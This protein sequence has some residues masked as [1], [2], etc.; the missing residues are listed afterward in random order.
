MGNLRQEH[1]EAVNNLRNY[2]PGAGRTV[3]DLLF[4]GS[5]T[6]VKELSNIDYDSNSTLSVA[7]QQGL[8]DTINGGKFTHEI[9]SEMST[10]L[11]NS[12]V[13]TQ[14]R[15]SR[16]I[17]LTIPEV[18]FTD[19]YDTVVSNVLLNET[20]KYEVPSNEN[21]LP[22]NK[23][24][25]PID[26]ILPTGIDGAKDV[27]SIKTPSKS[28]TP[29]VAY[30]ILSNNVGLNV[31][32]TAPVSIACNLMTQIA[33]S[34]C[35]PYLNVKIF[36]GDD[37]DSTNIVAGET[38]GFNLIHFLRGPT[39]EEDLGSASPMILTLNNGNKV[40]TPSGMELFTSP[41]T[42]I[43][44]P[45]DLG[46]FLTG[47]RP[48][49]R[50]RPLMTI[51]SFSVQVVSAGAGL[52]NNKTAS[53]ELTLHD[54]GRLA[55]IKQLV[56][57]G[58]YSK[59]QIEVEYGWS[60]IPGSTNADGL[61]SVN[62]I[63]D[64]LVRFMNSIRVKEKYQVTT[65]GYK[66]EEGGQISISLGL[67][68]TGAADAVLL[69]II[70][71][72]GTPAAKVVKEAI[73][74]INQIFLKNQK[75]KDI[76]GDTVA[77]AVSTADY[78]L[79][80]D[81][82]KTQ[83][84]LDAVS[85]AS[86]N[87]NGSLKESASAVAASLRNLFGQDENSVIQAYK[88]SMKDSITKKLQVLKSENAHAVFPSSADP[89]RPV[90]AYVQ[91]KT[92][93]AYS[94]GWINLGSIVIGLVAAPLAASKKFDEIQVIFGRFNDRANFM[95]SLSVASFP[96]S[97][98]DFKTQID[99]LIEENTN[100]TPQQLMQMIADKFV[101]SPSDYAYGFRSG[102]VPKDDGSLEFSAKTGQSAQDA[103]CQNAGIKD[104]V[105]RQ[106]RLKMYIE[107]VPHV[108]KPGVSILRI[109]VIDETCSAFST[110]HDVLWAARESDSFLI[111]KVSVNSQHPNFN[112]S[113]HP[114]EITP[115]FVSK[116][117]ESILSDLEKSGVVSPIAKVTS[118]A[119]PSPPPTGEQLPSATKSVSDVPEPTNLFTTQDV[120][121]MRDYF[122]RTLPTITYGA[123]NGMINSISAGVTADPA[124]ATIAI[125]NQDQNN[126]ETS[127]AE[128]RTG[129]VPLQA[130]IADVSIEML[131]NPMLGFAQEFFIDLGTNTTMDSIYV[132]T[133]IDHKIEPGN[134]TTSLKLVAKNGYGLYQSRQRMVTKLADTLD[135]INGNS[136]GPKPSTGSGR[137]S[138]TS[139]SSYSSDVSSLSFYEAFLRCKPEKVMAQEKSNG[140]AFVLISYENSQGYVP[141]YKV[142]AWIRN[143]KVLGLGPFREQRLDSDPA[144]PAVPQ[145]VF[146]IWLKDASAP[147]LSP[148]LNLGQ[149]KSGDYIVL[150]DDTWFTN[151][152]KDRTCPAYRVEKIPGNNNYN[153][154][155][156]LIDAT[157]KIKASFFKS[158]SEPYLTYLSQER[159][160]FAA[161]KGD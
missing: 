86:A 32:D 42:L 106:P 1:D 8:L 63:D 71:D 45:D 62:K 37:N 160:R 85:K 113:N 59:V 124:I 121:K 96:I 27:A 29:I 130:F 158:I 111:E 154:N 72:T 127:Q 19:Y 66:F 26:A 128:G 105:F 35:V 21:T 69:P 90:N 104:L 100:V 24:K 149:W 142:V 116:E 82:K 84:L 159:E 75:V 115:N 46:N 114:R 98:N 152:P 40:P 88:S 97:F 119:T 83:E 61:Y 137:V 95:R 28:T 80:L 36:L 132:V 117:R 118:P 56:V 55:E 91:Q 54:R 2:I 43:T 22:Q 67:S 103:A 30:E 49:D 5:G 4:A 110:Y 148:N 99:K 38:V 146:N 145:S 92:S 155:N 126:A 136:T 48:I 20:G 139:A 150:V 151:A 25:L 74:K 101:D 50:F 135:L 41:Q 120:L 53:M 18:D 60:A 70:N 143:G 9:L 16:F 68:M 156:R 78:A 122:K 93:T 153:A 131:G 81:K 47:Q 108:T 73:E 33:M 129:G 161:R 94:G 79:T 112:A 140:G 39:R 34:R 138:K 51:N 64:D 57:P 133:G 58:L 15:L 107:T 12:D 11:A 89:N 65:T 141:P 157:Y 7:L 102:F 87:A 17:R 134:F 13:A 76:F 44:H 31:R 147:Y 3:I 52:L 109:H 6:V 144:L 10:A 123:M 14:Y 77:G 125:V 23:V